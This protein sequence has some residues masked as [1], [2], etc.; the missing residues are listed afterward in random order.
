MS[1][2]ELPI[3]RFPVR[4]VPAEGESL[5]GYCWRVFATNGHRTPSSIK[6]SLRLLA[7]DTPDERPEAKVIGAA[8]AA[9]MRTAQLTFL[10]WRA[11]SARP[12]WFRKGKTPRFCPACIGATG[13]HAAVWDLPLMSACHTHGV[14]LVS[15]CPSCGCSLTWSTLR[16]GFE[17]NCGASI[18]DARSP[19]APPHELWLSRELTASATTGS[20]Q[21]SPSSPYQILLWLGRAEREAKAALAHGAPATWM[22]PPTRTQPASVV[23]RMQIRFVRGLPGSAER[24]TRRL[25]ESLL[26]DD[27]LTL[28]GLEQRANVARLLGLRTALVGAKFRFAD[29]ALLGIDRAL[30]KLDAKLPALPQTIFN[31]R[32]SNVLFAEA[33]ESM[34][35]WWRVLSLK[36]AP[37]DRRL[38]L[39]NIATGHAGEVTTHGYPNRR[40]IVLVNAIFDAAIRQIPPEAFEALIVRWQA[41]SGLLALGVSL[42][43]LVAGFDSLDGVEIDYVIDLFRHGVRTFEEGMSNGR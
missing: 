17:C 34:V 3:S 23:P 27:H 18:G 43:E 22:G 1:Q 38:Q 12:H 24:A 9:R 16:P 26:K 41:P 5:A 29:Q 30:A 7:Q 20:A 36:L 19:L 4:P 21:P 32:L 39:R 8:I 15:S 31:P 2:D 35:R 37:V 42:P 28:F 11:V 25:I 14:R 13:I 40:V 6:K 10:S 33:C